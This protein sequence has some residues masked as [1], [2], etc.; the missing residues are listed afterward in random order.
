MIHALVLAAAL[1]PAASKTA[2]VDVGTRLYTRSE[3]GALLGGLEI[4]VSAGIARQSPTQGGLA[5]LTAESLLRTPVNGVAL[6]DVVAAAGGSLTYAV[7]AEG[8]RFAIEAAPQAFP[9]IAGAFATA[10]S[11]FNPDPANLAASRA[12]LVSR[13]TDNERNPVLVGI[14]MVRSAYYTGA[15]GE[16]AL[17][18]A[19]TLAQL[20]PADVRGFFATHYVRGNT[21]V[22]A[23]GNVADAATAVARTIAAALP[24]GTEAAPAIAVHAL[25]AQPRRIITHRDVFAPFIVL[26]FSAPS[27]GDKDFAAMLVV[28]SLLGDVFD[29]PSATTLEALDRSVGVVYSY[30]VKPASLAL[31]ING[32][33]LN[34]TTG[35]TAVE[36]VLTNAAKTPLSATVLSRYRDSA[37]GQ[38]QIEALSLDDRAFQIGNAVSHGVDPDYNQ[39][40]ADAIAKTTSADVQ[41]VIKTYLQ[42]YTVAVV[43]PRET[44]PGS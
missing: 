6:R 29:R 22:T 9:A 19:A 34:P 7:N 13:I 35:L 32:A 8:V 23:V 11:T 17:G 12:A 44:T 27:L 36:A 2:V 16:P 28:R 31:Y 42:R 4:F 26:G 21:F 38:W 3:D 1:T 37:H 43:L 20:G 41:R 33:R 15:A 24:S 5:A 30:D 14:D 18:S 10:A 40:V 39:T 25:A